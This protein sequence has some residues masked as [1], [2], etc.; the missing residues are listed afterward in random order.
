MEYSEGSSIWLSGWEEQI[1]PR[2]G[3]NRDT[4][5]RFP[6]CIIHY[7]SSCDHSLG[8]LP[9]STSSGSM[10]HTRRKMDGDLD[11]K[12]HSLAATWAEERDL[13]VYR[14]W[15]WIFCAIQPIIP[16]LSVCFVHWFVQHLSCANLVL[17]TIHAWPQLSQ[18][19]HAMVGAVMISMVTALWSGV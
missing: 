9:F 10:W 8:P 18:Q 16:W 12:Q 7:L 5:S 19:P 4:R 14:L 13:A 1:F 2:V 11:S 17:S 15:T 3:L 6:C